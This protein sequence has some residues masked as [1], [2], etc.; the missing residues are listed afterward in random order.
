MRVNIPELPAVSRANRADREFVRCV[1]CF[2]CAGWVGIGILIGGLSSA[3]E[4]SPS[5][6][7]MPAHTAQG[8]VHVMPF[9]TTFIGEVE[10]ED[11][12]RIS[13]GLEGDYRV[14]RA[15]HD[16]HMRQMHVAV[17]GPAQRFAFDPE[18]GRFREVLS[19]VRV[20]LGNYDM[21]QNLVER[22]GATGGKV[23]EPLGF[24]ILHLPTDVNP[25]EAA[26]RIAAM[27]GVQNATI[28][29]RGPLYVP[30]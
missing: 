19:S 5:Q 9:D 15:L 17:D 13:I 12:T 28:Q 20:E 26:S 30:R 1:R 8:S 6:A 27:P 10:A 29:L 14:Y 23:Y 11:G 25:A 22:S 2:I 24:A 4:T 7:I 21:F 16:G 3:A 18:A